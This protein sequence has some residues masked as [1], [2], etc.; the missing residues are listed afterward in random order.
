[1]SDRL[2]KE[3]VETDALTHEALRLGIPIPNDPDWWWIDDEVRRDVSSEMW[4]LI[5]ESHEY[6]TEIGK[7]GAR[8]LIRDE[9]RRLEEE[10]RKDVEWK[11]KETQWKLTIAGIIVGWLLGVAGILIAIFKE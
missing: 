2:A 6:L 7:S 3:R 4:E 1:M 11:R 5:S 9:L 8:K 10:A